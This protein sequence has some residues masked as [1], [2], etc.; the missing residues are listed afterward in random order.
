MSDQWDEEEEEKEAVA[1]AP[2]AVEESTVASG[3]WV[4]EVTDEPDVTGLDDLVSQADLKSFD[5]VTQ[6]MV[7]QKEE[8]DMEALDGLDMMPGVSYT[9]CWECEEAPMN[10]SL[11]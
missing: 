3:P 6:A 11:T 2:T 5:D 7:D 4:V 10:H 1:E 9:G 8:E